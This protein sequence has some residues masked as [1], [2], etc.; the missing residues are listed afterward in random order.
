MTHNIFQSED[1][2]EFTN[3]NI[4]EFLLNI[5][6]EGLYNQP[7]L[8]IREYIQNSHDAIC[9]WKAAPTKGQIDIQIS[10]PNVHIFDNG[11]GMDRSELL[12]AMSNIG[13]SFKDISASS[14]FMGIGKLA[15]LSMADRVE[16][17]SCKYGSLERNWVTFNSNE[18]LTSIRERRLKGE[19][20]RSIIDTLNAHTHYN[21]NPVEES[22]ETHYTAVH[23]LSIHEEYKEKIQNIDF[24]IKS[25]G[26][27]APVIQDP[28]FEYAEQIDEMLSQKIPSHYQPVDIFINGKPVYRPYI[29][30]LN[31]PEAIH[32][33]DDE[34]NT[35]AYGW[36]CLYTASE[37]NKRQIPDEKLR[38]IQ[39]I[40]RG[41]AIGSRNLPEEMELYRSTGNIIYFRWY[42]GELYI[43]EPKIILSA[44]RTKIRQSPETFDFIR[45]ASRE[46]RKLSKFAEGFAQRDNAEQAIQEKTQVV[47]RIEKQVRTSKITRD[48]LPRVIS[49]L[50]KA[51]EDIGKRKKHV[52]DSEIKEQAVDTEEK[53][54]ELID[55]LLDH[56]QDGNQIKQN[57]L[58]LTEFID[59]QTVDHDEIPPEGSIVDSCPIVVDITEQLYFSPREAQIYQIIIE[60]ISSTCGG[61]ETEEFTKI[62]SAIESV[63][64]HTFG[65]KVGNEA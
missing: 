60:A 26:L 28:R 64:L 63:L 19:T 43:T 34:G 55:L 44:D 30:G 37:R 18:M 10:W 12:H 39:L 2:I 49:E 46:F 27:V 54:E 29:E 47:T 59:T 57:T 48:G 6:T 16:I 32:V 36:A 51:Q 15:G 22:P 8:I 31:K 35:V 23:L 61:K 45:S 9:E 11:P 50:S 56:K 65:D 7:D 41:I 42:S 53:I 40:Q 17:H 21:T 33:T 58:P 1:D 38:G 20:Q 24:F 13:K 25:I 5:L 52:A 3:E 4:G 62:V 14:G